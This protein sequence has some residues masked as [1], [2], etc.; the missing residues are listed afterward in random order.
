VRKRALGIMAF[1][2][3]FALTMGMSAAE[4]LIYV[5]ERGTGEL[6]VID[7]IGQ[8]TTLTSGLQDPLDVEILPNGNLLVAERVSYSDGTGYLTEIS[9]DGT[10]ISKNYPGFSPTDVFVDNDG[11]IY[12]TSIN[13]GIWKKG[14][15]DS[16]YSVFSM[17]TGDVCDMIRLGDYFYVVDAYGAHGLWRIDPATGIPTLI[18]SGVFNTALGLA[19][20]GNDLLVTDWGRSKIYRATG[21]SSSPTISDFVTNLAQA[22]SF[23]LDNEGNFVLSHQKPLGEISKIDALGGVSTFI[24]STSL[25]NRPRG[26]VFLSRITID[27]KPGSDPNSINLGE[28]GVLPVAILG[29]SDLDVTAIDP[30]TVKI[31]GVILKTRGSMKAPKFAYS[32]EDVNS[33]GFTDMMTFFD[34]QQL[35]S[36][37]VLQET[38]TE[39]L[40]SGNLYVGSPIL[41]SD[42]VNIVH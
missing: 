41:G 13:N 22:S 4:D 40:L 20:L 27:I 25:L 29:T 16:S 3:C 32:F 12:V 34:V 9:P 23:T 19:V 26:L 17:I 10:I 33:D 28:H 5:V 11:A 6:S 7:E 39:L 24:G 18:L 38:T 42:S 1:F 30:A 8:V 15:S 35:V 36:E 21:L 31:G 37:G 2:L 14:P